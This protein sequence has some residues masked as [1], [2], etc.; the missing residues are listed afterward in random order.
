MSFH[1][2]WVSTYHGVGYFASAAAANVKNLSFVDEAL[3]NIFQIHFHNLFINKYP[4]PMYYF[5]NFN[6]SIK[7]KFILN[8]IL[9]N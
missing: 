6:L 8:Q 5:S 1:A 2:F 4:N 3:G 9:I 7:L